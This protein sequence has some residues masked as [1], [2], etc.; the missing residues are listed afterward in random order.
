MPPGTRAARLRARTSSSSASPAIILVGLAGG[1]LI[2]RRSG[3]A[4]PAPAT[5]LEPGE[6]IPLRMTGMVR[7]PTGLE[8]LREAPGDLVRF[9]LGRQVA[10]PG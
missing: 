5:T 6:R 2:Y 3:A 4:L 8:H 1:Y 9:V 7:T 10:Q